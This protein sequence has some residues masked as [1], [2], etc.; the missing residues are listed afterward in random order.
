MSGVCTLLLCVELARTC[1]IVF[2]L[3][4]CFTLAAGRRDISSGMNSVG[5]TLPRNNSEDKF[6]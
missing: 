4:S 6:D 1:Y 2:I 3:A 5:L